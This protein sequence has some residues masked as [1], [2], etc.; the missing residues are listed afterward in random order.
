VHATKYQGESLQTYML[1]RACTRLIKSIMAGLGGARSRTSHVASGRPGRGG[2][3]NPAVFP[4]ALADYMLSKDLAFTSR[5]YDVPLA[6]ATF[7]QYCISLPHCFG[8]CLLFHP[9]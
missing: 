1:A 7:A 9:C 6:Y 3:E 8:L 4:L 5:L 2:A